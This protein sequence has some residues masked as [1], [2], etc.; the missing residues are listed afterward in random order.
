MIPGGI[1]SAN[2]RQLVQTKG[3]PAN[4]AIGD[5][6]QAASAVKLKHI[7][8]EVVV[9]T[10]RHVMSKALMLTFLI[11]FALSVQ[12]ADMEAGKAIATTVCAA[13]H[14]ANGVSQLQNS[15]PGRP[16]SGV[17]NRSTGSVS[18]G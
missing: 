2:V 5:K 1:S 9:G 3:L 7:V 11:S 12:A 8:R 17:R 10:T 16:A 14:G 13:C 6:V 15:T 4:L 18:I